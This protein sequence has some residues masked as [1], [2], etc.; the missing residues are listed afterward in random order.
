VTAS[1]AGHAG[2]SMRACGGGGVRV[3]VRIAAYKPLQRMGLGS[4]VLVGT[5]GCVCRACEAAAQALR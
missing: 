4:P 3:R 2:P 1:L 5:M